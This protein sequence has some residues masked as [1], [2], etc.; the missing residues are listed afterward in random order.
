MTRSV[1]FL[2]SFALLCYPFIVYFGIDL[3][4]PRVL[5]ILLLILVSLRFLT[6]RLNLNLNN[7][8]LLQPLTLVSGLLAI[9]I[10][11]AD[12]PFIVKLNPVVVNAAMLGVFLYTLIQPPSL[13]E[14]IARITEPDLPLHG[15]IYTR[16]VTMAWCLMFIFNGLMGLY[17]AI[18]STFEFWLLY[19]GFIA[20]ILI[21]ILF[22]AE[23]IVRHYVQK[24]YG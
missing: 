4:S 8:H 9:W 3:F 14:R 1:F 17:T 13:V 22:G 16:Y 10:I 24:K 23:F 19:N 21:S 6:A 5:G 11:F 2:V 7:L 20:Y 15:V 18:W 12:D